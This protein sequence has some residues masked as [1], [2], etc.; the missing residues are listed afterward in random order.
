MRVGLKN[1]LL[2]ILLTL[3]FVTCHKPPIN[4]GDDDAAGHDGY[5]MLMFDDS[6]KGDRDGTSPDT[7]DESA[8]VHLDVLMYKLNSDENKFESFYYERIDVTQYPEGTAYIKKKK[9]DFELNERYKIYVIANSTHD[10]AIF[11][12]EGTPVIS[13]DNLM[14]LEQTD[15]NIHLSAIEDHNEAFPQYFLMDGVAYIGNKEPNKPGTIII[16]EEDNIDDVVVKVKLRR[17]A[18]K[19]IIKIYP[20]ENVDFLHEQLAQSKGYMLRNMP[21]R[22]RVVAEGNY[23]S[24]TNAYWISSTMSQS[25]YFEYV[26]DDEGY[27]LKV[28][29]YCYSHKWKSSEFF[30]KGTSFI[31]ML[32]IVYNENGQTT[33]YVNNYYQMV[34]NKKENEEDYDHIIKRNTL[35]ELHVKLNAPGAEDFI[36]AEELNDI[37]YFTAPWTD[38]DI[39]V[40]GSSNIAYLQVNKDKLYM[41]GVSQDNASLYYSSSSPVRT[42]IVSG[43]VY[44]YDKHGVKKTVNNYNISAATDASS[45]SG[46]IVVNS[47]IPSNNTILYFTIKVTNQ[48]NLSKQIEVEQHP[49]VYITNSLPWY[50]YREDFYY[51]STGNHSFDNGITDKDGINVPTTYN[52]AG[53]RISSVSVK[54]VNVNNGVVTYSYKNK[55]GS[56]SGNGFFSSKHRGTK[57]NNNKYQS[58]FYYYT[59]NYWNVVTLDDDDPCESSTNLRNYHIRIMSTSGDYILGRP[60]MDENG[61]TASDPENAKLVSPSFVIASRLGAVY[62]S[63]GGLSGLSDEEKR[64]VFADHAKNYVEVDD[65][66][67]AKD[68]NRVIVYDNWRLPTEAE[69][70]II[71]ELQG[72]DGQDADA[73]D[74]L[75]NGKYYMS[76]S[77]PVENPKAT[78]TSNDVA[79]RCVRDVY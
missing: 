39:D 63:Y 21:V 30:E 74:Y 24:S 57:A 9:E 76:A 65:I 79:V 71:I 5:I 72:A 58:L 25:P 59:T 73:I 16:N 17:A 46:N 6:H 18:A 69:L 47:D 37:N 49:L 27:H 61:H 31:F 51:R 75:L 7:E 38:V 1:I 15:N 42:E 77:G 68:H 12:P 13:Y 2:L 19:Y 50:S 26:Q 41:Y 78:N 54:S 22:T 60:R 70:K 56:G 66:D 10:T 52:T 62:S 53:D 55:G 32:P 28:T 44:Y 3:V 36:H 48:E 20:G 23:P 34:L 40:E 64:I 45:M 29:A 11:H 67:D 33:E 14:K 8:L 35:Y 4:G 43:S